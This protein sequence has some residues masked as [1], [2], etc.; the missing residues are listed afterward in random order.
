MTHPSLSNYDID[1]DYCGVENRDAEST[2]A[3]DSVVDEQS[4]DSE[5][6]QAT[7]AEQVC[8][9]C[10]NRDEFQER[11]DATVDTYSHTLYQGQASESTRDR[12]MLLDDISPTSNDGRSVTRTYWQPRDVP[13]AKREQYQRLLQW[14]EGQWAPE[15]DAQNKQAD[16]RRVIDVFGSVLDCT[17]H[18]VATVESIIEQTNLKHMGPYSYQHSVLGAY[19]IAT[20]I[21]DQREIKGTETY[22]KLVNDIDSTPTEMRNIRRLLREKSSFFE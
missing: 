14:Q 19:S 16:T 20:F 12:D 4:P 7:D 18:Q 17:D 1:D 9:S 13:D 3:R 2:I 11:D 15:R 21:T 8:E 22:R 5:T 10:Q 6:S